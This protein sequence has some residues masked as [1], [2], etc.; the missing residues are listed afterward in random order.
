MHPILRS[1]FLCSILVVAPALRA[2]AAALAPAKPS[3]LV[4]V[5]IAGA[6][7]AT[8]GSYL[9]D[10]VLPNGSVTPFE[11]PA[12]RVFVVTSAE[13]EVSGIAAGT[14]VRASLFVA[15][16]A[17]AT[18]TVVALVDAVGG[19]GD[20]AIGSLQAPHGIVI[21][22]GSRLCINSAGTPGLYVHGFFAKDR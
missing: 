11:I 19:A 16:D 5:I 22:R 14:H 7:C 13:V 17:P 8:G 2:P 12:K 10:R 15:S 18:Q 1:G 9:N 21:A 20:L 3:D 6:E 4:T